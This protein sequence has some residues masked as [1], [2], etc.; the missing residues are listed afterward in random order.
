MTNCT[1]VL[2]EH[3]LGRPTEVTVFEIG[4]HVTLRAAIAELFRLGLAARFALNQTDFS[5][6]I[7]G[8]ASNWDSPLPSGARVEIREMV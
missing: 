3:H 8:A 2:P 5:Y 4:I 7:N 1:F 6:T